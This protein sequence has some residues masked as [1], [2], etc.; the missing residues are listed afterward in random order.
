[1]VAAG[2]SFS[3]KDIMQDFLS[4]GLPQPLLAALD[5]IQFKTPTPIQA[6]AIPPA[7]AGK[8]ILGSAQT[9]TG[10]TGAFGIPLV[11]KL[12][13]SPRGSA[14]IMTPTRELAVQVIDMVSKLIGPHS[15][16]KSVLL[17]GGESMPAQLQQLRQR[18]R[19]IVGTPGRINDHLE[20]GSLMLHDASFLVLDETD[21]MLD[22]GFGAQID[23][24][25]KFLPRERQTLL[26][27]A[28]LPDNIV[29]LSRNYLKDPVRVS[30]GSVTAPIAKIKQEEI[31]TTDDKKFDQ[32]IEQLGSRE[33]SIIMFVKTKWGAEKMAIRLRKAK[34]DA[35]AIHGDL[36]QNKRERVIQAFRD[37]KFRILVATDI[38]ARG[39]DI[40]HIEHVINYDLPQ[41]PEDYIHRV[42]RTGRAGAEGSAVCFITPADALKWRAIQ[43]LMNPGQHHGSAPQHH[44]R[45]QQGQRAPGG[46]SKSGGSRSRRFRP[47]GNSGS[48][49][50]EDRRA[51]G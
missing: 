29:A 2:H 31:H 32:L 41:A 5:R 46:R 23:R 7:L 22:M 45:P 38:A 4:L 43:R 24:I 50:S 8:D 25:V 14:L 12:M 44:S 37:C 36:R 49:S 13:A 1:M 33:G 18:P 28:T 26:F 15:P 20:R 40:P 16:I 48:K 10:K 34:Q 51:A 11:A 6:Q 3:K 27:S 35:E 30:V 39:L 17:I 9:G 42:G 19:L 21:R 47:R